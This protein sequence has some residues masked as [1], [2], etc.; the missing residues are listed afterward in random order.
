M[1]LLVTTE[2][3]KKIK[4]NILDTSKKNFNTFVHSEI[5]Q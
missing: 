1:G 4:Y 3:M 5:I 2:D